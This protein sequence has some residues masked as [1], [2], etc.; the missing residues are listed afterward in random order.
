M[1]FNSNTF[2]FLFLPLTFA[3]FFAFGRLSREWAL[4]WLILASLFFYAWW[5]PLNVL[6]IAP[7]ILVNY[8]LA[9][10]LLR[11]GSDARRAHAATAVLVAGIALNVA[12]LMF[13]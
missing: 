3:G 13:F 8:C 10:I 5:R 7:S 6:L 2:I 11:F 9:R 1:L 12:F 4:R